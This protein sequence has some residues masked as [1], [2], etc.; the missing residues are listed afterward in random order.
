MPSQDAPYEVGY[1]R[2]PRHSQF[3]PGESGNPGGRPKGRRSFKMD[4]AAALD[5]LIGADSE[6]TKQEQLA[7]NLVNDALARD[8]LAMRIVAPIALALNDN[9]GEREG[10]VTPLQQQLIEDFDRRA[11]TA[12][13]SDGGGHER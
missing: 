11:R 12:V 4:I 2:P 6:R 10:D 13:S 8:P 5:K 7:E 1:G 9:E 3:R